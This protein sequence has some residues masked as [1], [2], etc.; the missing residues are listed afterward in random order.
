MNV[1]TAAVLHEPGPIANDRLVIEERA[2]RPLQAGEIRIEIRACGDAIRR[3]CSVK[4]MN[5]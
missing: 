5:R 1:M 4:P 3:S 2:V